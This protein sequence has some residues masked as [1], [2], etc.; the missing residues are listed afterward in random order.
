MTLAEPEGT[1][2]PK[3]LPQ[4]PTLNIHSRHVEVDAE[5]IE[6]VR[7]RTLELD[8]FGNG[9]FSYDVEI[10]HN[11]NRRQA[12]HA[13]RVEISIKI[14]G[15]LIRA[16]GEAADPERAFESSRRIMEANLRRAARRHHWSRHGRKATTKVSEFLK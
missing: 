10:A 7:E 8:R 14:K 12:G 9:I 2:S 16:T 11:E 6:H 13:W 15:H 5:W 3:T 4:N 1:M